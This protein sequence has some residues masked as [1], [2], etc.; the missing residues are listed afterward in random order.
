M[1]I[2]NGTGNMNLRTWLL[3]LI[4]VGLLWICTSQMLL[5]ESRR[6][7]WKGYL[8]RDLSSLSGNFSA[9]KKIYFLHLHKSGGT[10][11]CA[12]AVQNGMKA[13]QDYCNPQKDQRCCGGETAHE[14]AVFAKHTIYDFVAC[15]S[16]MYSEMNLDY[17]LYI[18]ILRNSL[19]RYMSHYNH[20]RPN[21]TIESFET[22]LAGQPDNWNVRH[23]C[24][25]R[26]MHVPKFALTVADFQFAAH[27]LSQFSHILFHE[28]YAASFALLAKNL[29]WKKQTLPHMQRS[30]IKY[31]YAHDNTTMMTCLDDLLYKSAKNNSLTQISVHQI[32]EAMHPMKIN[33]QKYTNPCGLR[34]SKH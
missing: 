27:R 2:E 16:Y 9:V 3:F 24:G 26:C 14:Q 19:A 5:W 6:K 8:T 15:E 31:K 10:S 28:T 4:A 18:T 33:A 25:T 34:C 1:Y 13:H 20:A 32:E 21:K 30:Q 22:W 29:N 12:I 7:V 11:M 17:Y 23:I